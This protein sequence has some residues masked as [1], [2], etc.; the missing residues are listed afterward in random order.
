[1][2]HKAIHE[3]KEHATHVDLNVKAPPKA[4]IMEL[5]YQE[6]NLGLNM[7]AMTHAGLWCLPG[8][9]SYHKS[10][11]LMY[12]RDKNIALLEAFGKTSVFP[13]SIEEIPG[14]GRG[15]IAARDIKK[16]EIVAIYPGQLIT[17]A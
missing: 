6:E 9:I 5:K 14:K 13:G 11:N 16:D 3:A 1:M 8:S 12:L 17:Q 4:S 15:V 2:F 10:S 7:E